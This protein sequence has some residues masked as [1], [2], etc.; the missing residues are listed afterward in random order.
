VFS[1]HVCDISEKDGAVSVTIKLDDHF[2]A[3]RSDIIRT[4]TEANL[5][6][7]KTVRVHMDTPPAKPKGPST[8]S[9]SKGLRDVKRVV[10]VHSCKGGVGK[11]T[12]A[13]NLA[14][15][16]ANM[17]GEEQALRVG[18]FDADI[19]GPSLPTM[20]SPRDTTLRSNPANGFV[21]PPVYEGVKTMSY[22]YVRQLK[23]G[24]KEVNEASESGAIMRG[25]MVSNLLSQLVS[26]T[27]WGELDYLVLDL[28]PG[29]G[30][31][32]ITL[33]QQLAITCAVT[34]TTPQ[35]L[36][37]VDVVKGLDMF[38]KVRVPVVA[39]VENMAYFVCDSCDK[40]HKP[41]GPGFKSQLVNSFGIK[42]CFEVPLLPSIS[43]KGDSGDPFVLDHRDETAAVR[44]VYYRLA[45]AVHNQAIL[46][47]SGKNAPPAVSY[48]PE[49]GVVMKLSKDNDEVE[50]RVLSPYEL[51][52][53]CQCAACVDEISGKPI[54]KP[55]S[56]RPDVRPI[57]MQR[58]GNYAVA[59]VWSDG[60]KSSIYPYDALLAAP[61]VS[62]TIETA[63]ASSST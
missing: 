34:V 21:I 28:P 30:D 29:T 44:D 63:A 16:L 39:A 37:F 11:S 25:P 24:G 9:P 60:H 4:L 2:R 23:Q 14:Y 35:K 36:S 43:A 19:Y 51:R 49:R 53:R 3:L 12:V 1:G 18:I 32:L 8:P 59:M 52:K 7:L 33:S 6:W 38:D 22:G 42:D 48:D 5:S 17:H 40:H 26:T 50:T 20:V 58:K 61:A 56:V 55:Q 47:A 27:D 10:A 54:L 13:V 15:A 62:T 41:F 57:A 31:I 45:E 46:I